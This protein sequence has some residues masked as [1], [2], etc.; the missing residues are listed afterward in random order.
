MGYS[1]VLLIPCLTQLS[2]NAK[3]KPIHRAWE[4][5]NQHQE[6]KDYIIHYP[7]TQKAA[8]K[9]HW[10]IRFPFSSFP[11]S[12]GSTAQLAGR[13]TQGSLCCEA[14]WQFLYT[15]PKLA[16]SQLTPLC[17]P[18]SFQDRSSQSCWPTNA[19][20]EAVLLNN[21]LIC[22]SLGAMLSVLS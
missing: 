6:L 9:G 5:H 19:F 21:I 18:F 15:T 3:P 14:G 2:W 13:D 7:A 1:V 17:L 11:H 22:F 4:E 8:S 20:K 10:A 16:F 12:Q